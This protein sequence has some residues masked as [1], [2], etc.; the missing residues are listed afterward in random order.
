M[1]T[2]AVYIDSCQQQSTQHGERLSLHA[3]VPVGHQDPDR[4]GSGY[5]RSRGAAR[6][7]WRLPTASMARG[8]VAQNR[9]SRLYGI[10]GRSKQCAMAVQRRDEAAHALMR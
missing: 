4:C 10:L 1:T 7:D 8:W 2:T 9:I 3:C 5:P 6:V